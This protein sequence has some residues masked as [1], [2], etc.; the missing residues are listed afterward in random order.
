M[1]DT[2]CEKGSDGIENDH[3]PGHDPERCVMNVETLREAAANN[4][5]PVGEVI[6]ETLC[7]IR[8]EQDLRGDA[9]ENWLVPI[10][11]C[12]HR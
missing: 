4:D 7:A 10:A 3:G 12:H 1:Y 8:A 11:R 2:V 5:D 6:A 9:Q